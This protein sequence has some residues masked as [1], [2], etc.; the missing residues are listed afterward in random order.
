MTAVKGLVDNG[1]SPTEKDN[2]GNTLKDLV[3]KRLEHLEGSQEWV[4]FDDDGSLKQLATA[5]GKSR[6]VIPLS[7]EYFKG[8]K[9][10]LDSFLKPYEEE[11]K[12]VWHPV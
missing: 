1:F 2:H 3:S 6:E 12:R 8:F 5:M 10:E 7:V 9:K 4:M 11:A